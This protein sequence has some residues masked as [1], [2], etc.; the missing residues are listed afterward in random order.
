MTASILLGLI[1]L[2][3]LLVEFDLD[4]MPL[5]NYLFYFK[6]SNLVEVFKIHCFCFVGFCPAFDYVLQSA[7][8]GCD[9][10]FLLVLKLSGVLLSYEYEIAPIFCM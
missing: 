7:P 8:L 10:F 5:K 2:F 1:D 9:F 4:V 3:K 6:F